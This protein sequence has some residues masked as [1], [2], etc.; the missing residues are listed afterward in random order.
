MWFHKWLYLPFDSIPVNPWVYVVNSH[1]K[2]DPN[3]IVAK[4]MME[5][6]FIEKMSKSM[7][8]RGVYIVH[9]SD[10]F[11]IV[12]G[13]NCWNLNKESYLNYARN[14]IKTLQV[15]E[16]GPEEI[17]EISEENID[18]SFWKLWGWE[19]RPE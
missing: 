19:G 14:Y 5:H 13:S 17:S 7:D 1:E 16:K 10:K 15:R 2:E 12:I 9:T 3:R 18:E 6:F 8:P 11:L 4:L